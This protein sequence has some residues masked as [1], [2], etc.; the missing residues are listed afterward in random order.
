MQVKLVLQKYFKTVF[1]L[2]DNRNIYFAASRVSRPRFVRINSLKATKSEIL[3]FFAQDGWQ[4]LDSS[5]QHFSTDEEKYANFIQTISTLSENQFIQD[6]HVENL[7]IFPGNLEFYNLDYY[8]DGSLLLQD[9]VSFIAYMVL[10]PICFSYFSVVVFAF[11]FCRQAAC[12]P[13]C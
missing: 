3:N 4:E 13:T 9:K 10:A 7:L 8:R 1:T 6:I 12:Q 2:E 5:K 11:E